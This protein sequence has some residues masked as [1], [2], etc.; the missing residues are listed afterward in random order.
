MFGGHFIQLAVAWCVWCAWCST[1]LR[2]S[3]GPESVCFVY[4]KF[5]LYFSPVISF[6]LAFLFSLILFAVV[7]FDGVILLFFFSVESYQARLP[8]LVCSTTFWARKVG[9]GG[10]GLLCFCISNVLFHLIEEQRKHI[11]LMAILH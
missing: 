3:A 2:L 5:I 7:L 4:Y 11:I 10:G 9:G 8:S 6:F 1:V